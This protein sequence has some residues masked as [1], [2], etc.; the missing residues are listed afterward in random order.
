MT[1][2]APSRLPDPKAA[3]RFLEAAS[4]VWFQRFELVPGVQ[5]P[6]TADIEELL[7]RAGFPQ[8]LDGMTVLDIGTSNGGAAFIA[9]RRGAARVVAVDIYEPE[10]FGVDALTSFLGSSVEYVRGS[11][12]EL[13]RLLPEG[14]D[15]VLLLGVLYHLR[16]PLLALDAVRAMTAGTVF[17]ETAV[18]DHE[19][20]DRAHAPLVRFY[21]RDELADDSSNWFA[22]TTATLM[23]WCIS[24]GLQP[25]MMDGW[26]AEAPARAVVCARR[27][28]GE[29]EFTQISY[30]RHLLAVPADEF[31]EHR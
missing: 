7:D 28:D 25:E 18:A 12:Y 15:L 24:C 23:E 31:S 19:L 6:G 11:V 26:P 5:T 1:S 4:F 3:R 2:G 21:R 17:I 13:P 14:F 20:G 8:N 9:E 16:H 22:P 10:W 30:E 27:T 29:P